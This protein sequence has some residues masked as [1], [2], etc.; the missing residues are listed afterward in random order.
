[1]PYRDISHRFEPRSDEYCW[2]EGA[3][4][5]GVVNAKIRLPPPTGLG[6]KSIWLGCRSPRTAAPGDRK[7]AARNTDGRGRPC[8]PNAYGGTLPWLL[9]L[10]ADKIQPAI[11]EQATLI[12]P[13]PLGARPRHLLRVLQISGASPSTNLGLNRRA[14]SP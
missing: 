10:L 1:M 4:R 3:K 7:L 14:A 11:R 8:N 2:S 6:R 13:T 12:E 9:A 5:K